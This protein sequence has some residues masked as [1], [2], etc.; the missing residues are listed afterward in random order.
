MAAEGILRHIV[1]SGEA[2]IA[3][4]DT[5]FRFTAFNQAYREGFLRNFGV[6][7][8]L[9]MDPR[10][11]LAHLP[12]ER[13]T[14]VELWQRA[15]QGTQYSTIA[16]L[17]DAQRR[18]NVYELDF[19][20]L[21]D[22]AGTLTGAFLVA[23]DVTARQQEQ[24]QLQR[25]PTELEK[26]VRERTARLEA[27]T[28]ELERERTR[29]VST[30]ERI[31]EGYF[32]LDR[33]WRFTFLNP[34]AER[35]LRRSRA[36][37]LG[38]NIWSLLHDAEA[39]HH[40][41]HR[42]L[43]EQVT[44]RFEAYYPPLD[45]WFEMRVHP[46][47]EGLAVF[48]RDIRE[49]KRAEQVLRESELFLRSVLDSLPAQLAVLDEKG[50]ILA[51]NDAWRR[52]GSGNGL[53]RPVGPCGVGTDYL[54]VTDAAAREGLED[55]RAA[56]QGLRDLLAGRREC[57]ELEYDCPDTPSRRCFLMRVTRFV[58]QG[59]LRVLVAHEDI[60]ARK[61]GEEATRRLAREEAARAQAEA[62]REHLHA[63]FER[64]SDGFVAYDREWRFT[65]VNRNAETWFRRKR[66]ELLGQSMWHV[67]P[68]AVGSRLHA[69]LHQCVNEQRPLEAELPSTTSDQWF[70][71]VAYP[72]PEGISAYFRDITEQRVSQEAL[73]SSEEKLRG[74]VSLAADAIIAVDGQQRI[75][76]FNEGARST[77]G[78]TPE[79]VLGQPLS[80][81][82]PETR[83]EVHDQHMRD[84]A[85]SAEVASRRMGARLCVEG[86]RK[87]GEVFPAEVSITRIELGNEQVFTAVLRDIT[88][89][90][91]A[92][93][94][95]RFLAEVGATLAH[96]LDFQDTLRAVV[97]LVVPGLADGCILT[98]DGGQS[99]GQASAVSAVDPELERSL[100]GVLTRPSGFESPMGNALEQAVR[101]GE[102]VVLADAP[103]LA[104]PLRTP[105]RALGV[106]ALVLNC[107]ARR[108][109]VEEYTLVRELARRA[110]L[111]LEN[112]RL[113]HTA[114]Q[115][116]AVRD[117]TLG[118]V[119]H[120]LRSPLSAI[121]LLS[122]TIELYQIPQTHE[123]DR[124]RDSLKR[125]RQ[126]VNDMNRLIEDLLAVAR[127]EAGRLSLDPERLEVSRLFSQALETLEPLA[128]AKAL[129]LEAVYDPT[130]P[131]VRADRA[132]VLQ[133]LQNLV[134]N[135]IKFTPSRGSIHLG[136]ELDG[137]WVRFSV[138]DTGTGIEPDALPHVFDRFWQARHTRH[139]GAG[140]GLAIVKGIVEAHGGKIRVESTLGKGT[141]FIFT[142]P[143]A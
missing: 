135:A 111:A 121:S 26:L 56:A 143:L 141:T 122:S 72:S 89:Q 49:H 99:A 125:I 5:S 43:R 58:G 16:A 59:P 140:L 130:L 123:G 138:S 77:F 65:Y 1:E 68:G 79:E 17:G 3:A 142:L 100:R 104:V 131:P 50:V 40:P 74:I 101:T 53:V 81:L 20:P 63:V 85:A 95:Q 36:E 110:T 102:P 12:S 54:A 28:L 108:F 4:L 46:S 45:T 42:A 29:A 47:V 64:I 71:I 2:L 18:R 112:A 38:G 41:Y 137:K 67:F 116:I 76:I 61:V 21:R 90:R 8:E 83:R 32:A 87:G 60:T 129:R 78:Y 88:E 33:D 117:E 34:E 31:S 14:L 52:S 19:R 96:S 27:A 124:A 126:S 10:D 62:A 86:R 30:L 66:E 37:L 115:A 13:A 114:Q 44:L 75:R 98:A 84:F 6:P 109:G 15:F 23:R 11:A 118:I 22:A 139:M 51:V 57:F 55:A 94:R 80:L 48:F 136:A 103:I 25:L 35:L 133:V 134:G 9:G 128:G 70:R 93:E 107:P 92:E 120:D 24:E 91:R 73:R 69:L 39:F 127:M 132:R 105:E 113:Y 82:L 7:I 106:L 119:S 97:K